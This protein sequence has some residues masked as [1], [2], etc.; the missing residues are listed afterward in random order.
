MGLLLVVPF[1]KGATITSKTTG[2]VGGASA[3][4]VGTSADWTSTSNWVGGV[5]PTSSDHVVI[6][7]AATTLFDPVLPTNTAIG[8]II[9]QSGGI[10]N[11]GTGTILTVSDGTGAWFNRGTFNA[12]TSEVVFTNAAAS[13]TDTTN[14]YNVT[15]ADGASL[16]L[17]TNNYMRIAGSLSLSSSGIFNAAQNYNT[18]EYNGTTDQSVINPNG[19]LTGFYNLILSGSG[20]KTF[21]L[22]AFSLVGDFSLSGR[23][24]ATIAGVTIVG[25]NLTISNGSILSISPA[26]NL[27]V[28]GLLTNNSGASGFVLKSDSTGT[29]S[30][31]HNTNNVP[32]TV[33]RFISGNAKEW[34]FLS[35]PI[36]NQSISGSW[37]PSGTYGNGTGYDLYLW[38]EPSSFWIYKMDSTSTITWN[39]LHP[40]GDFTVGR[41]YLYSAQ[42]VNPTKVFTGLLNNG[43]EVYG[44]TFNSFNLSLK[45]FNLV[46]NPYP[47][48]IDW[49][50]A[51]GWG[52][53]NLTTTGGGFDMWIWNPASKNYGV[54]NSSD[55]SGI[56]TNS[57]TRYI[58]SMQGYF[59][60]ASNTGNLSMNNDVRV[61]DVTGNKFKSKKQVDNKIS[62]SVN[63]DAGYG[64]DEIQLRFGFFENGNGAMKLFSKTLTA[65]SLYMDSRGNSLSVQYL[66]NT[67]ENPEVPLMFSPGVNGNYT[68]NCNFDQSNFDTVML[69][70]RQT[71]YIQNLK[72]D[73]MYGFIAS[74]TDDAN[75]FTLHFGSIK[76]F[77]NKELLGRI[78]LDGIEVVVDLTL[79]SKE[80]DVFIYD[81]MGRILYQQ[82]LQ[83][84]ILHRISINAHTQMLIVSIKNPD[85]SYCRKLTWV[86]K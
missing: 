7:D 69:E 46:G 13:I 11:G 44:L 65:L 6:P 64:S 73:K 18:V 71:H 24:M 26:I 86:G 19:I 82:K 39:A 40:G 84:G 45:G 22:T 16:T 1:V 23:V 51:T 30:L 4:W 72:V 78:Y 49:G 55:A 38:N 33:E 37:M 48:P 28:S 70:D 60:R 52:R 34:H 15:I 68:F 20:T 62:L 21:P 76:T 47:S 31:V 36:V 77:S 35:S 8:S 32:A 3:T 50:A 79:I 14:F 61:L 2:G 43:S 75:R 59:V 83:G 81:I 74:K 67:R 53:S 17:G 63:S 5:V 57:V 85:G 29:A 58:A 10:L 25:G 56:G 80:T 66:T 9:I 54:Y 42:A 41:G 27:T 12:G